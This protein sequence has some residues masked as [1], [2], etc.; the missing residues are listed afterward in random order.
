MPRSECECCPMAEKY[1]PPLFD[2]ID[3]IEGYT[4]SPVWIVG[5]NPYGKHPPQSTS[6]I[7]RWISNQP[8]SH[9]WEGIPHFARLK[10]ILGKYFERLGQ[11]HGI[12]STDI[13]KCASQ[14]FERG[15]TEGEAVAICKQFLYAQLEHFKPNLIIV[16]GSVG[17][18]YIEE[19]NKELS[20]G[21]NAGSI[22]P[23]GTLRLRNG[24]TLR[25]VLSGY[26][27]YQMERYAKARLAVDVQIEL[28]KICDPMPASQSNL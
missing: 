18:R 16:L 27:G 6:N 9:H 4:D 11:E 28:A 14:R 10:P 21:Q 2:P 23:T 25:Y 3:A 1:G 8:R 20:G 7:M 15:G 12:A 24:H 5:L 26:T 19:L 22:Q 13:V 17:S